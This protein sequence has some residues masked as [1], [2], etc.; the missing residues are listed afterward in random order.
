MTFDQLEYWLVQLTGGDARLA[1]A[2]QIFIVVLAV[3]VFNPNFPLAR[4]SNGSH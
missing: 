1:M 3:V 2:L 4:I